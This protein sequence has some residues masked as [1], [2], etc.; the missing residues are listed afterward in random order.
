MTPEESQSNQSILDGVEAVGGGYVWDAEIFVV[1]LMD[2]S[3]EDDEV[4]PL[5]GLRGVQQIA[6]DASRLSMTTIAALAGIAGLQT[7][8]LARR[9][10]T[11]GQRSELGQFG[12]EIVEV[13]D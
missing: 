6:L 10:L 13:D 11:E 1:T 12:P 9:A 2:V 4:I 7:L 8:V 5:C 3:A